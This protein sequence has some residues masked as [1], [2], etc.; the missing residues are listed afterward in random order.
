MAET[1]SSLLNELRRRFPFLRRLEAAQFPESDPESDY[2]AELP[3]V[4]QVA[5]AVAAELRE[6]AAPGNRAVMVFPRSP[7]VAAWISVGAAL[8]VVQQEWRR[9]VEEPL[10]FRPGQKLYVDERASVVVE[11]EKEVVE[12]GER[13]FYV[14]TAGG[15]VGVSIGNRF[16]FRPTRS[17]AQPVQAQKF[18]RQLKQ[19]PTTTVLERLTDSN[20]SG[21][22]R[23]VTN[24]VLLVS[25][26]AAT[27]HLSQSTRILMQNGQLSESLLED[28]FL[29]GALTS[30]GQV[31]PWGS[32]CAAS[33]PLLVVTHLPGLILPYL[34]AERRRHQKPLVILDGAHTF[35]NA[36]T[37]VQELLDRHL[38][39]LA[40]LE[41]C[42]WDQEIRELL[43]L[44]DF[45]I[46]RW[47]GNDFRSGVLAL[48]GTSLN[49]EHPFSVLEQ[50]CQCMANERQEMAACDDEGLLSSAA[51]GLIQ[52]RR[53]LGTDVDR[54]DP[55]LRRWYGILLTLSR[56]LRPLASTAQPESERVE[57]RSIS[58][59]VDDLGEQNLGA[60]ARPLAQEVI[61]NLRHAANHFQTDTPKIHGFEQVVDRLYGDGLRCGVVVLSDRREVEAT[62]DYWK[63]KL[64]SRW[65]GAGLRFLCVSD[66]PEIDKAD[67]LI[68]SGWMGHDRMF[69]LLHSHVAPV[70]IILAYPFEVSWHASAAKQWA[71]QRAPEL[72]HPPRAQLLGLEPG[73]WELDRDQSPTES[74]AVVKDN[75]EEAMEFELQLEH[76]RRHGHR[77]P[78][79]E[80]G[81][82]DSLEAWY[83][84]FTDSSCAYVTADRRLL[85]VSDLME[86]GSSSSLPQRTVDQLQEG[87]LIAFVEGA[88]ADV[89]RR[90]A[91]VGLRQAGLGH[92]RE[93]AGRWRKALHD[94]WQQRSRR[95]QAVVDALRQC[96]CHRTPTTVRN[97][98]FTDDTIGPQDESDL[99][100]I[101]QATGNVQLRNSLEQVR[102]AIHTVRG[103][104]LQASSY[105]YRELTAA[106][107]RL[108]AGS[109]REAMSVE[110]EG[111]G[112]LSIVEVQFIDRQPILVPEKDVNR[113]RIEETYGTHDSG[114]PGI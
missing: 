41:D 14:R 101:V 1:W 36:T 25:R 65:P 47:D 108:L 71:R 92:L 66:V 35:L 17:A 78:A 33:D 86:R 96:G 28:L 84:S 105:L 90:Q 57:E 77:I 34:D 107:P 39:V 9:R 4:L 111:V 94:L 70:T 50:S 20:M 88:D 102:E 58:E 73:R 12:N 113:R 49:A 64:A 6:A 80:P 22:D 95:F 67:F 112:R 2:F 55:L 26:L 83:V 60:A 74:P 72:S 76:S 59:L 8:A 54:M 52:F 99:D 18:L 44:S 63:P 10:S 37:I 16:R 53:A 29:W 106:L 110:V 13:R 81:S 21:N 91:D 42:E 98:I 7:Q 109:R 15:R 5:I 87:D 45:A 104:H 93:V 62:V 79:S 32:G 51:K 43:E 61:D 103:A 38:P 85:I 30:D 3:G 75:S 31:R 46:W 56:L 97:W 69:R 27:H 19:T 68:I 48:P 100:A 24:G 89:L 40:V 114:A 11:F 82:S 23:L